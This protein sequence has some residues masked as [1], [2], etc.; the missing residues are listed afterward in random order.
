[1]DEFFDLA[2]G[3][4]CLGFFYMGYSDEEIMEGS[5]KPIQ[6]KTEWLD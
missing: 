6:D 4:K 3:E 2:E 5:R 1:M